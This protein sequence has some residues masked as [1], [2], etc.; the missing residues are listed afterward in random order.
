MKPP[1]ATGNVFTI[2]RN[3]SVGWNS[4]IDSIFQV[5]RLM[6]DQ[7]N[8]YHHEDI[9]RAVSL[10]PDLPAIPERLL[11]AHARG[12]VAFICGAGVSRSAR[13]PDFQELVRGVYRTLDPT[14][15]EILPTAQIDPRNPSKPDCSHLTDRQTAEVK[16]FLARE[17]DVVLGML[18]RRLDSRTRDDSKVRARVVELL[19]S[20]GRKR[21]SATPRAEEYADGPDRAGALCT[22]HPAPI[23]CALIR[24]ADRGGVTTIMTSNFDLL[25]EAAARNLRVSA[26]TFT[27]VSRS[28]SIEEIYSWV[29]RLRFI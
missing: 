28:L 24:L 18:E 23:H 12:E 11:L 10:G 14:I 26:Q 27:P 6:H 3:Y 29:N 9:G 21:A 7:T 16:R 17:Y 8:S 4:W 25:L 22:G 19:H 20:S 2:P 5:D 15:Y 13:L 1:P